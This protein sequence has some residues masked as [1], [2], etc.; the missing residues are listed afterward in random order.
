MATAKELT[1]KSWTRK[2]VPDEDGWFAFIE[3]LPGCFADG[4]SP[5]EAWQ[6]LEDVL[7]DWLAIALEQ[8]QAIPEP[9]GNDVLFSGRF[10][11]RVP[12][13]LHRQLAERD[14]R[15]LFA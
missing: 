9:R 8:G 6:Q 5:E 4:D 3:E 10:S 2:L 11:V 13:S 14:R 1:K 12:R 7:V 15:S